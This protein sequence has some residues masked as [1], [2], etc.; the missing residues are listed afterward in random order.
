MVCC[1]ISQPA[2]AE[3]DK[4]AGKV[5]CE[6]TV[7]TG[8]IALAI[9]AATAAVVGFLAFTGVLNIGLDKVGMLAGEHALYTGIGGA[10]LVALIG[11]VYT[12]VMCAKARNS[13]ADTQRSS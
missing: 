3:I 6:R 8:A 13:D 12:G 5:C 1:K 4:S 7:K 2:Q 10:A 11:T 9:I